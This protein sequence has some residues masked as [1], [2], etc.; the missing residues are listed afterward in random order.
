MQCRKRGW[1]EG[2]GQERKEKR[3]H[4]YT[5]TH[6]EQLT[7]ILHWCAPGSTELT[8]S[9]SRMVKYR[10]HADNFLTRFHLLLF[11]GTDMS[12]GSPVVLALAIT[13]TPS[14]LEEGHS[15]TV[16]CQLGRRGTRNAPWSS[17]QNRVWPMHS[18]EGGKVSCGR[19]GQWWW[20]NYCHRGLRGSPA[21]GRPPFCAN[22]SNTD[23][24][25]ELTLF[26]VTSL[27]IEWQTA[28]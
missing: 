22:W 6:T 27:E 16:C 18:S 11:P 20:I 14:R 5:Y 15:P 1:G 10:H 17:E 7:L 24:S 21:L 28:G 3:E 23:V 4:G 25:K 2:E 26:T 12:Q 13:R 19:L 8:P 9:E